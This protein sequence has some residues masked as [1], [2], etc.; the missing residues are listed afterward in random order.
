[1]ALFRRIANLFRREHLDREIAAELQAHID[2]RID[3]N[4]ARGMNPVEAR[5]V[6]LVQFGNPAATREHVAAADA[7]LRLEDIRR[8]LRYAARQLRRSPGFALTAILT[9]AVGIGGITAVCSAVEAV[10]LHPLAFK[11][12]ERLVRLHEGVEHHFEPADL[13]APDVIR[14]A[15]DNRSFVQVAGFVGA[16]FEVSGAGKPFQARAE[17]ITASLLPMLG[18]QPALGRAFTQ[19][20]DDNSAPVVI[21]S[22]AAWRTRFN[23]NPNIIGTT[24]DLDRR[25][26]T[27]LGVMPDGFQFPLS[28][29]RVSHRDLWVPMSFTSDE[30]QDETDN[31]QYGAIARLQPGVTLAQARDNLRRMVATVEAEIPP[32]YGIHLTSSVQS[33]QEESVRRARPLLTALAA[34]SGMILLMACANL[35]NLLLVRAAGRQREFGVRA[36]LGAARVTV[37]RQLLTESLLLS[38]IGGALGTALAL[39]LVRIAAATLPDSLPQSNAIAVHWPVFLVAFGLTGLT[40]I[41]CGLAPAL[42]SLRTGLMDALKKAAGSTSSTHSQN[43]LRSI[44]AILEIALA[45][46]LLVGSGLLVR[47]FAKMLQTDPGF[48]AQ[49]VLTA[50]LTLPEQGYQTQ[51]SINALYG[52]LLRQT[53][54]LPQTRSVGA[55][56]NIPIV[57]INSDRNFVPLGYSPRDGRAW[58]SASNYFVLG[59]Y[60]RA[61][62]IP[63][64]EGRF[65]AAQDEQPDAPLVAVISQSAARL[66][67]PGIDP[68][69]RQFRMGGNPKSARPL[70]TVVGV[71]GDVRQGALDQS[72]YPQMYEP[73]PQAKRQFETAVQRSIGNYRS[74][75]VVLNSAGDPAVPQASLEKTVQQL[76]PLLALSDI[77]TMDSVVSATQASRRFDTGT[78]SGFAMVALA[79]ALL[80]IYGVMAHSVSERTREIA[81]RM[82][83]GANRREVLQGILRDALKLTALGTVAGL[84]AAAIFT[85]FLRSL[86]YG[87]TPLDAA[88]LTSVVVLLLVCS[89]MAGLIPARRASGLDPMRVLRSE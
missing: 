9:L 89:I 39:V 27:I 13:P 62:R 22:N 57:G 73:F 18:V 76:D 28:T 42:A 65:L 11:Q 61:M 79:L 68:I 30:K 53:A 78:L 19:S 5:R 82:A 56:T 41:V 17:R 71:V 85:R 2:L 84:A 1:M 24:V 31:F 70:I 32:Q 64:I 3:D 35:A 63:L 4:L 26:Y 8:D 86:L 83:L 47:S 67:W 87:V 6:A 12:P 52:E 10:L 21:I 59:D 54:M 43:R 74:L 77:H 7:T 16:Q 69:G 50:S 38:A 33:L 55:A 49:H 37:V 14:F 34:A 20:E 81:I 48:Q 60:F 46:L 45:T 75:Y 36:A 15:R 29:G 72:V 58:V 25:P 80:G 66:A 40:G 88:T 51:Q 23:S 44:L